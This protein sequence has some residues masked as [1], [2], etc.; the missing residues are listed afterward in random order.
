MPMVTVRNM[1]ARP[2]RGSRSITSGGTDKNT[3]H[4]GGLLPHIPF[5]GLLGSLTLYCTSV[6]WSQ[7]VKALVR[8]GYKY[9][10]ANCMKYRD[11]A[12]GRPTNVCCA[13]LGYYQGLYVWFQGPR[14]RSDR[15]VIDREMAYALI[16]KGYC[17]GS[18]K[19]RRNKYTASDGLGV[20]A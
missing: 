4:C 6:Q 9:K 10:V 3:K 14:R 12:R 2:T 20:F 7:L 15:S 18:R 11:R 5:S 8:A 19:D 13:I 16:V 1:R 17:Y